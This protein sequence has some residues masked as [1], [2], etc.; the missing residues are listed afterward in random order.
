MTVAGT[1]DREQQ[2]LRDVREKRLLIDRQ[3]RWLVDLVG[4][5]LGQR[6]LEVGCGWGNV[7]RLIDAK[8]SEI[9]AIDIDQES[10]DH[11]NVLYAQSDSITAHVADICD[12]A[13]LDHLELGY[14]AV[15]T[16]NV[17]EHI[18]DDSRALRNMKRMLRPGGHLLI[19]VPAHPSIYNQMDRSIGHHRRYSRAALAEQL[20][21]LGCEIVQMRYVNALGALGWTFAGRVMGKDTAP[22]G[23]L[24]LMNDIIPVLRWLETRVEPPFGTSLVAVARS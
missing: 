15:L 19:V 21:E 20:A 1:G 9:T 10:V 14:D 8:V 2:A 23:Q 17:L 18:E 6:L 4:P 12:E 22:S 11:V 3:D 24:M 13:S 5:Y 16:I 7:L